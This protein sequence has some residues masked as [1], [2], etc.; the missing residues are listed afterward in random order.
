MYGKITKGDIMSIYIGE[1]NVLSV[2]RKTDIGYMLVHENEEIFL[3][4]NDSE[5][6]PLKP[7]D[8]VTAFIYFDNKGRVA[9]TLKPPKITLSKPNRLM[10][11]GINHDLGVFLDMG[12]NKDLLLSMDDLPEDFSLWPEKGDVLA[13]TM[14]IKGRLVAKMSDPSELEAPLSPLELKSKVK[15]SVHKIGKQGINLVT[16]D[17]HF[18]FVHHSL[19]NEPLRLGQEVSV[20][21]TFHSEKGYSGSL[22]EQ[23]EVLMHD[24][25]NIILSYLIKHQE[26]MLDANSDPEL[27]NQTFNMSKKAF[28]RAIGALYKERKIDFNNGKT[29]LINFKGERK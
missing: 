17:N 25:A 9:A 19:M 23:K 20:K 4:F 5:H 28:K 18:I 24:D 29:I 26:M 15:A 3:H 14:K 22:V 6:Q 21:V 8:R 2:D 13:I 12:I 16:L 10:V 11:T 1:M 7:N 27:I